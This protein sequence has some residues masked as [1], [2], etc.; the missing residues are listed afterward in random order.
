MVE[1][2]LAEE[3]A[4][5]DPTINDIVTPYGVGYTGLFQLLEAWREDAWRNAEALTD[6][7]DDQRPAVAQAIEDQAATEAATLAAENLY[8]PPLT[9]TDTRDAYC[10]A[11]N[12]N[13]PPMP[14]PFGTPTAY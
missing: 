1:P 11:N 4:R 9:T 5:L 10:A 13:P 2:L 14:Y 8:S 6:A 7:T 3:A 12:G